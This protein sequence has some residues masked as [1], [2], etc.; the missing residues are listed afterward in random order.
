MLTKINVVR[1]VR[2]HLNTLRDYRTGKL[3]RGDFVLFYICPIIFGAGLCLWP[4]L[5]DATL[6]NVLIQ[7]FAILVGLLLNL[8]V[9]IFTAIRRES[10]RT[11][12][13]NESLKS[14][15]KIKIL[16]ETFANLSYSVLIGLI[17]ALLL[18]V[19]LLHR[20]VIVIVANFLIYAGSLN[21]V[22]TL[23]MILKRVHSLLGGEFRS[24]SP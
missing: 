2:D 12:D 18:L 11:S 6:I 3:D 14:E 16:W 5:L 17:I 20:P 23:L 15:T 4:K 19:A 10:Q 7:A 13:P 9:L 1:I 22:L 8:L 21:F 24:G